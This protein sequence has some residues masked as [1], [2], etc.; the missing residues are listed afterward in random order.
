MSKKYANMN[1]RELDVN[2]GGFKDQKDSS[3]LDTTASETP[4]TVSG[5]NPQKEYLTGKINPGPLG[6][7]GRH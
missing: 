2:S 3:L 4:D 7:T 1:L 6:S 5:S